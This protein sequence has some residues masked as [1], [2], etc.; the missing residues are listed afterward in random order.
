MN[1]NGAW[2]QGVLGLCLSGLGE[3]VWEK[4]V[5]L[6]PGMRTQTVGGKTSMTPL[7]KCEP[8]TVL[9]RKFH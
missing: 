3:V 5:N 4:R 7:G 8:T 6:F 2:N 1:R 9:E